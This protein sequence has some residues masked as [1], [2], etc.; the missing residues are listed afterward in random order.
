MKIILANIFLTYHIM[1]IF[2]LVM[3]DDLG[4]TVMLDDL[5]SNQ[6]RRSPIPTRLWK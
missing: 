1:T 5:G 2:I 4:S 3:M 6:D